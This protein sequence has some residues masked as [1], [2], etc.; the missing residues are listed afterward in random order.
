MSDSSFTLQALFF[1]TNSWILQFCTPH[2]SHLSTSPLWLFLLKICTFL[3]GE[4]RQQVSNICAAVLN[5]FSGSLCAGKPSRFESRRCRERRVFPF[6]FLPP[7]LLLKLDLQF[8]GE[9]TVL[10]VARTTIWSVRSELKRRRSWVRSIESPTYLCA[11][12]MEHPPPP[13][14]P[15]R[16]ISAAIMCCKCLRKCPLAAEASAA[17]LVSFIVHLPN[18]SEHKKKKKSL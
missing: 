15:R 8:L 4:Y 3:G 9:L 18:N 11:L 6:F 2:L 12:W 7:P 5:Y 16:I 17:G 10:S 1:T 13:H 14:H